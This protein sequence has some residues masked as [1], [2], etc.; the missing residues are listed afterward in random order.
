MTTMDDAKRNEVI[1]LLAKAYNMELETVLNFIANSEWLD[2]I[3]AKH[4]KD[5]LAADVQEEIGHAQL[6]AK[7]IKVLDGRIPGSMELVMSQNTLQPPSE[8]VDVLD[9]IKGVIDAE[10]AAVNHYQVIIE[11]TDVIDP[12]TQDLC[13]T[14]KGDEEEHRREFKGFLQEALKM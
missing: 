2:G 6:L 7:R 11:A 14:I 3:R 4:I 1:A 5:S 8:S 10:E 13:I 12:V 9:V